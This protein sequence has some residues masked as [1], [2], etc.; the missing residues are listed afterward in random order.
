M[1]IQIPIVI[2]KPLKNWFLIKLKSRKVEYRTTKIMNENS[3]N[4]YSWKD[5]KMHQKHFEK[6]WMM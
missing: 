5:I 4:Y 1:P 3:C 6:V 2:P